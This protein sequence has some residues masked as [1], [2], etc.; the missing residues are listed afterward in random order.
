M[1]KITLSCQWCASEFSVFPSRIAWAEAKGAP[2]KFCSRACLGAARSAGEVLAKRRRGVTRNCEICQTEMYLTPHAS[3]R[4][5]FCTEPCRK[6]AF[7]RGM[8][9]ENKAG[10]KP[11]RRNGETVECKFCGTAVYRRPSLIKRNIDKTCGDLKCI[12]AYSRSL[13]GLEP[14]P[15]DVV[16]LPKPKRKQRATNFT[17]G[18][19]ALWIDSKCARCG[20]TENLSLDHIVPVCAGGESTRE[21]AQTLCQ[22]CNNWKATHID[23][24]LARKR[25]LSGGQLG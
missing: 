10:P 5:R 1:P 13:W 3:K 22:P 2:V 11:E 19:R 12:S 20:T 25:R 4:R 18:Q 9:A 6:E 21:N 16:V 8:I 17:N 23:R 24:P 15:D 14:R 7:K